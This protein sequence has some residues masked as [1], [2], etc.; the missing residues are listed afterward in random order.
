MAVCSWRQ[1]GMQNRVEDA[2]LTRRQENISRGRFAR[3]A[4]SGHLE[5]HFVLVPF[6]ENCLSVE[7][8]RL[9][10]VLILCLLVPLLM[11][12]FL[13]PVMAET[14]RHRLADLSFME[15]DWLGVTES[16]AR[17]NEYWSKAS[18]DS[19][20]GYCKF[21][22]KGKTSFLELLSI[23]EGPKGIVMR[24]RHFDGEMKPWE[25]RDEAGD[26]Q[27]V[28]L[29][30]KKAIFDNGNKDF[31]VRLVYERTGEEELEA[32][33]VETKAGKKTIFPFKYHLGV[34]E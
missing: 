33:V 5:Y 6:E 20:V 26:C 1:L 29:N 31:N 16:G 24:M 3:L 15:G 34:S 21:E 17:V 27:L 10:P 13:N 19:M 25:E 12:S 9:M 4:Y 8:T 32:T 7:K 18:G 23:V 30:G 2:R 22:S 28:E 11:S 14:E